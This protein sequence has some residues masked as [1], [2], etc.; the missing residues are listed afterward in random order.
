V[1]RGG[2]TQARQSQREHRA[3]VELPQR[4][5]AV[6]QLKEEALKLIQE[7]QAQ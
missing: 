6:R 5:S 2:D 7:L 1:T 4:Q 3:N